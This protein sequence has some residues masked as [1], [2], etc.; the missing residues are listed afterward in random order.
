MPEQTIGTLTV[1]EFIGLLFGVL[2]V[3]WFIQMALDWLARST[4]ETIEG[5]KLPGQKAKT[6]ADEPEPELPY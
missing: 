3:W 6:V 4:T 5:L 2:F 1:S